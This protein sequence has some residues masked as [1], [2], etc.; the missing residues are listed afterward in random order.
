VIFD[1]HSYSKDPLPYERYSQD[2]RPVLCLGTNARH[3]P[4]GLIEAAREAFRSLGSVAINRPTPSSLTS[5]TASPFSCT[6]LTVT[7]R[8]CAYLATLV[9][10]SAITK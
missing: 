1:L 3:T 5:T 4:A 6:T 7:E 10:A 9:S 8:A 2:E